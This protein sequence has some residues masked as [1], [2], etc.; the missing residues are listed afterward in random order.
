MTRTGP[1]DRPAEVLLVED[2]AAEVR[3]IVEALEQGRVPKRIRIARDGEEAL[4]L[5]RNETGLDG[6]RGPD[7]VLL[8]LNLPRMDGRELLAELKSDPALR[9]IPIV[10]LTTSDA[11]SDVDRAYG[12]HANC[13]VV[14]PVGLDALT[15]VLLA[16]ED[17]WLSVATLPER[18]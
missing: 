11:E 16:I 18:G 12:L 15:A 14:K 1:R 8:D 3:V 13:Y 10:V 9:R 5:I 17:F 6:G 4:A 7:L 2:N